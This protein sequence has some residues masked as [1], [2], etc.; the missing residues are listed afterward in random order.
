MADSQDVKNVLSVLNEKLD[1]LIKADT[2]PRGKV[3]KNRA[4]AV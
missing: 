1:P 3:I 4:M 2:G